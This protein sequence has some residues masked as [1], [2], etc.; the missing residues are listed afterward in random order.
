M[1]GVRSSCLTRQ[2]VPWVGSLAFGG[3]DTHRLI[4]VLI[5][6]MSKTHYVQLALQFINAAIVNYYDRPR[7]IS[8]HIIESFALSRHGRHPPFA[9]LHLST[10]VKEKAAPSQRVQ[11]LDASAADPLDEMKLTTIPM[12]RPVYILQVSFSKVVW[13]RGFLG[14]W[15]TSWFSVFML[16][17][18]D[19]TIYL[20]VRDWDR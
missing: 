3:D 13:R 10:V 20:W 19:R 17:R 11:S 16:R 9:I 5:A 2:G 6:D 1:D 8:L 18:T 4:A 12:F 7:A 14:L 15:I